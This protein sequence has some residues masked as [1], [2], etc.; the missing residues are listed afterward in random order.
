MEAGKQCGGC[1]ITTDVRCD[2]A[3]NWG[4]SCMIREV[5]GLQDHLEVE[6][7]RIPL[8]I[9]GGLE[10]EAKGALRMTSSLVP[11]HLGA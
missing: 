7:C 4:S 9:G 5:D 10:G 6:V 3:L 1:E 11:G 8:F 2:G